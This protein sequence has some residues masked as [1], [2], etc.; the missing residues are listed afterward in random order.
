MKLNKLCLSLL[1][2]STLGAFS[3][4]A[5]AS[6]F[7]LYEQDA[8]SM[9]DYHSGYAV[10]QDDS[11]SA[12]FYNPAALTTLKQQQI[13][14]GVAAVD[15]NMRFKGSVTPP[16]G[17]TTSGTTNG[18]VLAYLPNGYYALPVSQYHMVFG[19]GM[20]VPF[21]LAT[22]YGQDSFVS[23][24]ATRTDMEIVDITPAVG[25]QLNQ[26]LSAGFGLDIE[27]LGADF[28]NLVYDEFSDKS[29]G[30][31]WG[32]GWHGGILIQPDNKTRIGFSYHSKVV[33]KLSGHND[34]YDN[35]VFAGR[36]DNVT[37]RITMPAWSALSF[38]RELSSKWTVLATAMYTEWSVLKTLTLRNLATSDPS[39]VAVP[40]N[41]KNTWNFALGA[42]YQLSSAWML[43]AGTGYD[44][45]PTNNKYRNLRLPDSNRYA[46][47][48]GIQYNWHKTFI[49]DLGY[50]HL[51]M[52]KTAIDNDPTQFNTPGS[53]SLASSQ[54]H[55]RS[56]AN[57]YG[58]QVTYNF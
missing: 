1:L 11:A 55:V 39:T 15:T 48:F 54:G 58:L 52:P 29:G 40:Q 34:I 19:I 4:N 10:N 51:F 57:L 23:S 50:L 27:R 2:T 14:T 6:A 3:I 49:V 46:L 7:Q 38:S 41:F 45:T 28:N 22:E 31:S 8:G 13:T 21:G 26:W 47:A 17:E 35:G 25:F 33:Q 32:H 5:S 36:S 42:H 16:L 37:S 18:G 30:S 43:R 20:S 56:H 24:Y 9:G 44:M 12:S 53:D